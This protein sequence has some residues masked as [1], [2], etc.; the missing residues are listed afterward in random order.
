MSKSSFLK[1]EGAQGPRVPHLLPTQVPMVQIDYTPTFWYMPK[2]S[3]SSEAPS[4]PEI[5]QAVS[6]MFTKLLMTTT[7]IFVHDASSVSADS[8]FHIST[9]HVS[10]VS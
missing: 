7:S 2:P 1:S 6:K 10:L 5:L 9:F 8:I 4:T 3:Q